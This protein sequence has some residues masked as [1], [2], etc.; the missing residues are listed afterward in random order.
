M[1][2]ENFER[3]LVNSPTSAPRSSYPLSVGID[4]L[5]NNEWVYRK[6][7]IEVIDEAG[8]LQ[9]KTIENHIRIWLK[10][11]WIEQ[12]E[13]GKYRLLYDPRITEEGEQLSLF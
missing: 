7:L 8:D 1:N 12:V 6:Y 11:N 3:R 13:K 10:L 5:A 9:V 2:D 4:Y